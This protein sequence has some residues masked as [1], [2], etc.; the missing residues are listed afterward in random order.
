FAGGIE[1]GERNLRHVVLPD[2]RGGSGERAMLTMPV[3]RDVEPPREPYPLARGDV[4]EKTRERSRASRAPD[5]PTMQS[6][7]HH[8]GRPFAFGIEQVE[9]LLEIGKKL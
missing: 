9:G 5:Q 2:H 6:D 7:R 1:A 4:V 8:L 3:L